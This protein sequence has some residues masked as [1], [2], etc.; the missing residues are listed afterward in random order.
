[1][2]SWSMR[3]PGGHRGGRVPECEADHVRRRN[4]LDVIGGRAEVMAVRHGGESDAV[5]AGARDRLRDGERARRKREPVGGVDE[6]RAA[7]GADN[8]RDCF[9]VD[10][11]EPDVRG[12]LRYARDAVRREALR[13]RRD[14]R[15]R[16][17]LGHRRACT[18][19]LQR[20]CHEGGQLSK[21]YARHWNPEKQ[22]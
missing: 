22:P 2:F 12:V 11:S 20:P 15:L 10:A 9:P 16:S 19:V 5:L 4:R 3:A 17:R 7:F 6:H 21:R 18:G 13:I 8:P 14:E 1:M